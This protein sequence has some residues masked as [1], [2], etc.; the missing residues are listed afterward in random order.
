[1]DKSI[2]KE[3][4]MKRVY[5]VLKEFNLDK[6]A[7][8]KIGIPGRIKGISGGEKRRLSFASEILTDPPLLYCDEPTSGLGTYSKSCF[9]LNKISKFIMVEFVKTLTWPSR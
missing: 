5:Q 9:N 8:V 4:K 2:S 7:N 3:A 1:M 6:R